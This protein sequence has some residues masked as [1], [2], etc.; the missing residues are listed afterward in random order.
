MKKTLLLAVLAVALFLG[1]VAYATAASQTISGTSPVSGSVTVTATVNPKIN[2]TIVSPDATNTVNFGAV[3]PGVTSGI[4]TVTLSVDSNKIFSVSK[5]ITGSNAQLGLVTTLANSSGN[6]KGA[7]VPFSDN[8][9]ITPPFTTDPGTYNAFV[10]Y[11]VTQ[12]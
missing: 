9:T 12:P 11:T 2:L 4:K 1:A 8:Y 5:T 3:D 7:A 10:Q 6:A